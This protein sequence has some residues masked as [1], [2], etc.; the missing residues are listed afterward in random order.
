M[1]KVGILI[2]AFLLCFGMVLAG[3]N[4]KIENDIHKEFR[5]FVNQD[6]DGGYLGVLLRDLKPGDVAELGL[7]A[8]RGVFLIEITEGSP[9]EKSGLMKGD[10]VV[11]YQ[12]MPVMSVKQFQRMVGDTPPGREISIGL[13]R[14]RKK[15]TLTVEIGSGDLSRQVIRKFNIPAPAPGENN[16]IF[17]FP[18]GIADGLHEHMPEFIQGLISK[19]PVLGIEGAVMTPQMADYMGIDEDEGVLVMA[20][21]LDTPAEAA[22][23]RAGDLITAISGKKVKDTRD[24]RNNLEEGIL[25]LELVRNRKKI[26]LEVEITPPKAPKATKEKLRM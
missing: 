15:M 17:R 20:V 18:E 3:E 4:E 16:R 7:P 8:E 22:G 9:A 23:L 21:G 14:E 19:G 1:R 5:F 26:S 12:S 13:Y 11:E 24:L 10:V 2:G 6:D 25:E